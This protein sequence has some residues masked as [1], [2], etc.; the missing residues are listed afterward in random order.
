MSTSATTRRLLPWI[1]G[2][3]VS[4][5]SFA[6][7]LDRSQAVSSSGPAGTISV[8]VLV[9]GAPLPGTGPMVRVVSGAPNN[10]AP[11]GSAV[12]A[13][14]SA[15]AGGAL[16][17]QVN[18]AEAGFGVTT[19]T[20][21]RFPVT[22]DAN[23]QMRQGLWSE[24]TQADA[25]AFHF[26]W[27]GSSTATTDQVRLNFS[28]SHA[29]GSTFSSTASH[30]GS[31]AWTLSIEAPLGWT[32]AQFGFTL[33]GVGNNSLSAFSITPKV[34]AVPEPATWGLMGLGLIGLAAAPRR[35]QGR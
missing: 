4:S 13:P 32:P 27:T 23:V 30:S 26:E 7:T 25:T 9:N 8:G 11:I 16:V 12:T 28:A 34:F 35:R 22:L 2:L 14:V 24:L 17:W 15:A 21:G 18:A 5:T 1:A 6:D 10:P 3:L 19:V 20:G 31:G 33:A 29:D